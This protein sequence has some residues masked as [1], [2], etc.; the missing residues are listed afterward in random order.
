MHPSSQSLHNQFVMPTY[1]PGL[2][3]VRGQGVCVWDDA[4]K[5]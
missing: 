5:E 1:A 4:G 3:L 2:T